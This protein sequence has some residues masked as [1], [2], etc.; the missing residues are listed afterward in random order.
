MLRA[1]RSERTEETECGPKMSMMRKN[2]DI[3]QT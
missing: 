3:K 2:D 1:V